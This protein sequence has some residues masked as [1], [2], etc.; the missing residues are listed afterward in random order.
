MYLVSAHGV[1][2]QCDMYV[3]VKRRKWARI[4]LFRCLMQMKDNKLRTFFLCRSLR[5]LI[6][7][8][9]SPVPSVLF[10]SLVYVTLFHTQTHTRTCTQIHLNCSFARVRQ[11]RWTN[12]SSMPQTIHIL[13][14]RRQPEHTKK[15]THQK[16]RRKQHGFLYA[17]NYIVIK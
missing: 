14:D 5:L 2:V 13:V 1:I 3:H 11:R 12:K 7:F 16:R 8:V 15:K 4:R 17:R 6:F 9:V 10:L